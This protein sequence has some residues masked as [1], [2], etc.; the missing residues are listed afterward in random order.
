MLPLWLVRWGD[1]SGAL[2]SAHDES[3]LI[4][5]LDNVD[6]H[7][8]Y[9]WKPY[10]GPVY[11]PFRF[12]G[13]AVQRRGYRKIDT[14]AKLL[15]DHSSCFEN[16]RTIETCSG[17]S[18]SNVDGQFFDFSLSVQDGRTVKIHRGILAA[19][20]K[21]FKQMF[22]QSRGA[23]NLELQSIDFPVLVRLVEFL[24]TGNANLTVPTEYEEEFAD[25]KQHS[26]PLLVLQAAND[27]DVSELKYL[28]QKHLATFSIGSFTS[29]KTVL[30]L[31]ET[32]Q[33]YQANWLRTEA[34]RSLAKSSHANSTY[35]ALKKHCFDGGHSFPD[36]LSRLDTV[37]D[38]HFGLLP[39]EKT[40][41]REELFDFLNFEKNLE[42]AVAK[43]QE[44][45]LLE[46]NSLRALHCACAQY[47]SHSTDSESPHNKACLSKIRTILARGVDVNGF[48]ENGYTPLHICASGENQVLIIS[49]FGLIIFGSF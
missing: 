31:Y 34:L 27:Y 25:A 45:S 36:F 17:A 26:F 6:N 15:R 20:S 28:A 18:D 1:G 40:R 13:K 12:K 10:A 8:G 39:T 41:R 29:T 47:C 24:Y 49:V 16:N 7:S 21:R 38:D 22:L 11:I 33:R 44:Y 23:S 3:D 4:D 37:R 48:D 9:S 43:L 32:A 35:D 42:E 30:E 46:L 2:V 19:R 14:K 5:T